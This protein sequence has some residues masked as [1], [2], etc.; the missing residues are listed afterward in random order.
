MTILGPHMSLRAISLRLKIVISLRLKIVIPFTILLLFFLGGYY[1]SVSSPPRK[2]ASI[3]KSQKKDKKWK[4]V[5]T[6]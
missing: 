5:G 2:E 3:E 1:K 4:R 6:V